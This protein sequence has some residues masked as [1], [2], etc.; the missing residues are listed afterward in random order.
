MNKSELINAM[1]A[2]SQLSKADA[3]KGKH[4][5]LPNG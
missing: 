3:K 1:A 2:E 4:P 5:I